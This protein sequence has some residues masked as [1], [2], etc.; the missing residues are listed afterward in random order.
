MGSENPQNPPTNARG[1]S[2]SRSAVQEEPP[3]SQRVL[4]ILEDITMNNNGS[5]VDNAGKRGKTPE[6][7]NSNNGQDDNEVGSRPADSKKRKE[8]QL[9]T[10]KPKRRPR[11]H[12]VMGRNEA[13]GSPYYTSSS[14]SSTT[15]QILESNNKAA[16]PDG[17][18]YTARGC[19]YSSTEDNYDYLHSAS[20]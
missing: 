6:K 10:P 17:S 2:G 14:K 11:E 7:K 3:N 12:R 5:S 16:A 9:T 1:S 8:A 4:D 19:K 18:T 13:T 20:R 15:D